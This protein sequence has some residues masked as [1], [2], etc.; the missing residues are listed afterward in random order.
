MLSVINSVPTN[1]FSYCCFQAVR[2]EVENNFA[3][4]VLRALKGSIVSK[5]RTEMRPATSDRAWEGRETNCPR[6]G[7]VV[8]QRRRIADVNA[9][10]IPVEVFTYHWPGPIAAHPSHRPR[11][12][13]RHFFRTRWNPQFYLQSFVPCVIFKSPTTLLWRVLWYGN[14]LNINI[15]HN[16][17]TYTSTFL[18]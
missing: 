14:S 2:K 18:L 4:L 11:H 9:L 3:T 5:V 17:K 12:H 16:N 6:V 10:T 7:L 1:S 15:V 13:F 8:N